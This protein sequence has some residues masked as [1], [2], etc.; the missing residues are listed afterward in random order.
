[1]PPASA[2][3]VAIAIAIS[4]AGCN[5]CRGTSRGDAPRP[6]STASVAAPPPPP[7]ARIQA[8]LIKALPRCDIDHRGPF[9]DF[10][11][12]AVI[13]RFGWIAGQP[14]GMTLNEHDGSTWARFS[15]RKLSLTFTL[16]E[17]SS[18]FVAAR[19][20]GYG[21][22]SI[23]VALDDQPLGTLTLAHQQIRIAQTGTTTLPVDAG[24]HTLTL[25]F[26]GRVREGDAFA[27]LDWLRVGIPDENAPTYGPPTLR[28]VIAEA[29]A[30]GG[31]PHES[32]ALRAPGSVRCA[33]RLPRAGEIRTAVGVQ[34]MGEGEAEIRLLRDGQK[35]ELL[36][37][38][39]LEGGEHA[40]WTPVAM[41]LGEG[42][43]ELAALELRAT[44]SPKGGRV[45]FGDPLIALTSPPPPPTPPA[46]AVVIVVLDGVE[47]A[48]LPPYNPGA[49][50]ALGALGEL[51]LTATVFDQHRA[52][53]PIVSA[54]MASLLTG[55]PPTAHGLTD[56]GARL[57]AGETTIAGVAR[58]AAVRTAMFTGVPGS[59]KAF[60][61]GAS[62]ERFQEYSPVS[63]DPATAPFDAAAAWL[64]ETAKS[65]PEAHLLAVIHAR[66]GHPPWDV[67]SKELSSA[68]PP[69]YTG[70]IDPRRGAQ[71]VAKMRRSKHAATI[72]TEADRLR[73]RSLTEIA[74]AGQ[75]RAL[76]ALIAALRT[77]NLWDATLFAVTGD[78]ASGA[79]DF[80][81]EGF[82]LK[83]PLKEPVLSLPLYVHFPGGAHGGRRIAEPTEIIDLA[84]TA[85]AVLGLSSSRPPRGRDLS[86]V[87]SELDMPASVPQ[88]AV[89]DNRYAARAGDLVLSGK[90]P[91]PPQLCDL[92]LD[93]TCAFNRRDTMPIAATAIFRSVVADGLSGRAARREPAT[94]DPDT[95][96]AMAVWGAME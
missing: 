90:Y 49:S 13:G 2:L 37:T 55:L 14:P 80:F 78:V 83:D 75:D 79:G 31:V 74:L 29:A 5:G 88:I 72:I 53:T 96:A 33:V 25:R 38:V 32:L 56:A 94:L 17:T 58:D 85:L 48:Q 3:A 19:A 66:G 10:G 68:L 84:P 27:D 70:L 39:H 12:D 60:G 57:P 15:D 81:A 4:L 50:R 34:G 46:R 6:S 42:R 47:R 71:T 23:A 86:R 11:T 89:L 91:S 62:W 73:V 65:A 54:V 30:L 59:F 9:F 41:P 18:I 64:V 67:T 92:A 52:P 93:P 69:D 95:A 1:M 77:A 76:G 45:L 20:V 87:A 22:K 63:G 7:P 36:R 61:F 43:A 35:P 40:V 8:N 44:L 24:L 82:E 21:A 51:A 16:A 28:D 26:F